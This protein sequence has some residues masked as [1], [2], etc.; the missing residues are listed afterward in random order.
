MGYY[1]VSDR[2]LIPEQRMK[3]FQITVRT[4]TQRTSYTALAASSCDAWET[5]ANQFGICAITV[6]PASPQ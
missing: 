1:P 6:T 3:P 4:A 2:S 5:A